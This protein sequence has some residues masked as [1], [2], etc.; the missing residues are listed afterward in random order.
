MKFC[1]IFLPL[2]FA[3][4]SSSSLIGWAQGPEA[5]LRGGIR[6]GSRAVLPGSRQPR[7]LQGRTLGPLG[8]TRRFMG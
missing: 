3:L 8:R 2:V 1:R 5:R 7:V 6:E 4:L